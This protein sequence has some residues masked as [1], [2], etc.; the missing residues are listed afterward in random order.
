MRST[1]EVLGVGRNVF[2]AL[3]KGFVGASMYTGDKGKTILATIKKHDKKEFMELAKDLDKLGYNFIATTGTAKELREAGI[4][5][6]EVRRIGEESPN[7]M[8]LIKNKEIDLV[9][10]TPTKANDSK[11]DGFHIRRAAIERNI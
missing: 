3:Y 2:E 1:G 11:R 8:D 9:V 6:K 7:I 5:A 10:N 4:D